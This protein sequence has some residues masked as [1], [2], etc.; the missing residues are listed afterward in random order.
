M[1]NNIELMLSFLNENQKLRENARDFGYQKLFI[2]V[3][4][5]FVHY[6]GCKYCGSVVFVPNGVSDLREATKNMLVVHAVHCTGVSLGVRVVRAKRYRED[7]ENGAAED[8][9]SGADD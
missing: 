9:D 7:R 2:E 6:F 1:S 5:E 4:L 3:Q 8:S